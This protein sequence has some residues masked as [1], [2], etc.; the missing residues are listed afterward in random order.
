MD[1]SIRARSCFIDL[2]YGTGTLVKLKTPG[3]G[4]LFR[5]TTWL[6]ECIYTHFRI[7]ISSAGSDASMVWLSH[8]LLW[9]TVILKVVKHFDELFVFK[10]SSTFPEY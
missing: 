5:Y 10:L 4:C 7:Q 6:S 9:E 3:S 2:A 8:T 1:R